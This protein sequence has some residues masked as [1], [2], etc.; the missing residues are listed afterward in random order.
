MQIVSQTVET[1]SILSHI[2]QLNQNNLFSLC[3]QN[4]TIYL[5]TNT[6]LQN[7]VKKFK[8]TFKGMI[9]YL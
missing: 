8:K 5:L 1:S 7:S 6:G 3:D 9:L 2:L 4:Y